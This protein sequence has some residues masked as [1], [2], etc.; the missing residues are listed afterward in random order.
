MDLEFIE[1]ILNRDKSNR[2]LGGRPV[3]LK[4]ALLIGAAG[5]RFG[6]C[7]IFAFDWL[8]GRCVFTFSW[9][10]CLLRC[11]W[12]WRRWPIGAG[13]RTANRLTGVIGVGRICPETLWRGKD[14]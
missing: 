4:G 14:I 2:G 9:C 6:R 10:D 5:C 8:F 1:T 12:R 13:G 3:S 7:R 11:W